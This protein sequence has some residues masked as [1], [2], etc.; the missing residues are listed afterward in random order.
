[1]A[2]A[3]LMAIYLLAAGRLEEASAA[4]GTAV[5][6]LPSFGAG[7]ATY[8]GIELAGQPTASGEP[9]DP[10]QLTAAHR[11]LPL[12]SRIQ[13][14][15]LANGLST[16]VRINDRGPYAGRS[17]I[18]LSTAAARQI[19]MLPAGSARVGLAWVQ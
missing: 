2:V 13:V 7:M 5:S 11:T 8:Y 9:F 10:N 16:V 1:M 4:V 18:D 3:F 12:G 17:V 6:A 14:T 19:G 15:N